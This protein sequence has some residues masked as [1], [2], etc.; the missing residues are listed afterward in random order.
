[1]SPPTYPFAWDLLMT[2]DLLISDK[3]VKG[4]QDHH[5]EFLSTAVNLA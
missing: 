5:I 4:H 3:S 1:M 2:L